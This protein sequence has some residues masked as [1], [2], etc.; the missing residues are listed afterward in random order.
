[1]NPA[2]QIVM[3]RAGLDGQAAQWCL[4][5]AHALLKQGLSLEE[6]KLQ[7]NIEATAEPWKRPGQPA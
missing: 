5:R 6:A 3:E 2:L 7:M 4:D 1:M